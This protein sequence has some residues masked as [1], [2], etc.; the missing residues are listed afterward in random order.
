MDSEPELGED[1]QAHL[2]WCGIRARTAAERGNRVEAERIARD[3]VAIA[4]KTDELN[5]RA[6][7]LVHLGW[8]LRRAGDSDEAAGA[9]GEAL[10]LYERKGNIA[11]AALV[12]SSFPG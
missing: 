3:G 1:R 10:E 5:T 4:A 8:V 7:S 12:R 6:E 9:V 11:A 2:T